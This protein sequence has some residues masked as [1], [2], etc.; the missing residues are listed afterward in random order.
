MKRIV[1]FGVG[2]FGRELIVPLKK[3]IERLGLIPTASIPKLCFA[4]DNP[5]VIGAPVCGVDVIGFDEMTDQDAVVI[6]IGNGEIRKKIADR[7]AERGIPVHNLFADTFSVG[8]DA[9]IGK[10]AVFCDHTMITASAKIGKQFQCNIYSYVAHDCVIGDYVTF[11][12]RVCCNGNVHIGDFAYIG[13][14]AV[15]KQGTPDK[16][17]IIGAG[18]TVGMGAVVTK[19]VAPG[20]VVMGNPAK[21]REEARPQMAMAS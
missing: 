12:P 3:H 11:A 5:A 16:P 13:T 2:G 19:D 8:V 18:A 15:I 10:G 9:V 20:A 14:G 17:L 1:I 21:P 7:C 6:A 4:D